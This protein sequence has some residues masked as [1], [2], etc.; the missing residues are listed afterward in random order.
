VISVAVQT[1]EPIG[2]W[3][4]LGRDYDLIVE[5]TEETSAALSPIKV[6]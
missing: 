1:K 2:E 5:E 3:R 4:R 6:A